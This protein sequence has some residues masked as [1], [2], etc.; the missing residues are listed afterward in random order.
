MIKTFKH[1]QLTIKLKTNTLKNNRCYFG[2]KNLLEIFTEAYNEVK[3]KTTLSTE[4]QLIDIYNF[5][6]TK[7]LNPEELI[8]DN[9]SYNGGKISTF[10]AEEKKE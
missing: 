3:Y 8:L 6:K 9:L 10:K 5:F 4:R 2:E 1:K 7:G